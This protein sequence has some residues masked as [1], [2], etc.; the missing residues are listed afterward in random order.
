MSW[1]LWRRIAVTP[2]AA[3]KSMAALPPTPSSCSRSRISQESRSVWP[4]FVK[5]LPSARHFWPDWASGYGKIRRS[6]PHCGEKQPVIHHIEMQILNCNINNGS[7]PLNAP[8]DGP[9]L[10]L[11]TNE[12]LRGMG[13]ESDYP[14]AVGLEKAVT[15]AQPRLLFVAVASQSRHQLQRP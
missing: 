5:Q 2:S 10:Y 13:K 8:G 6:Y 3:S 4:P 1:R 7:A 15:P 11:G 14:W 12:Q 9:C